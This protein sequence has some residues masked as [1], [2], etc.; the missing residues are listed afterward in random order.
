[1]QC[2]E[3]TTLLDASFAHCSSKLLRGGRG[4]FLSL[5]VVCITKGAGLFGFFFVECFKVATSRKSP[6]QLETVLLIKLGYPG[7]SLNIPFFAKQKSE[8]FW[9]FGRMSY[10]G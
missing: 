7:L 8:R 3:P 6:W 4:A 10:G 5:I 2:C 1:M 9:E